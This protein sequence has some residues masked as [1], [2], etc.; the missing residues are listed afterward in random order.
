M[1]YPK[2]LPL[3]SFQK[4]FHKEG[5]EEYNRSLFVKQNATVSIVISFLFENYFGSQ[6]LR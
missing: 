6:C 3:A 4:K 2:Q 5:K 1:F